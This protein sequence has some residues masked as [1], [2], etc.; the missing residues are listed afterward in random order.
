[1]E[2]VIEAESRNESVVIIIG[3]LNHQVGKVVPGNTEKVTPL[4]ELVKQLI[5]TNKYIL[6]NTTE[7]FSNWPW[8]RID[9][10]NSE[11][12]SV[13]DLVLVSKNLYQYVESMMRN[14]RFE[15]LAESKLLSYNLTKSKIVIMR[16]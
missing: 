4:W 16:K 14:D 6:L 2:V 13:L 15:A 7:K 1:M 10:A 8:T 12:K 9:P 3:D 11:T 5:D